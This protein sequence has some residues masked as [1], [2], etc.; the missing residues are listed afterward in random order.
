MAKQLFIYLFFLTLWTLCV[1]VTSFYAYEPTLV[2]FS[3]DEPEAIWGVDL[4]DARN[5]LGRQQCP[6]TN[7]TASVDRIL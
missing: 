1:R 5:L 3:I 4:A 6:P 2:P 7:R